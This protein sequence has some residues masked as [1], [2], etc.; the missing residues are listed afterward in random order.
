VDRAAA[1]TI[2][3][4]QD[5]TRAV[6]RLM[7]LRAGD[8]EPLDDITWHASLHRQAGTARRRVQ[9]LTGL[10]LAAPAPLLA[11]RL[12]LRRETAAAF[13]RVLA[14][15]RRD[16][17]LV[18]TFA[19][20]GGFV[21]EWAALLVLLQEFI[22][23]WDV[24]L[25]GRRPSAQRIYNRD[26]WRCM[27][28]GCTSRRNLEIHHVMYRSQ[29][30]DHRPGNL[31]CLCRFHHQMGEHGL[32]AKVRGAAPLGLVWRLGQ[33]GRGGRYRNELRLID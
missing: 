32:L 33:D 28:P 21:P 9:A 17:V 3:R 20:A 15:A 24:D 10:A 25:A 19:A 5:E 22:E 7:V 1:A 16:A 29:G 27:A 14:A 11:L 2:K 8:R 13:R 23:T 18:Q 12:I 4:L 26:G 30:G 31:I 6:A